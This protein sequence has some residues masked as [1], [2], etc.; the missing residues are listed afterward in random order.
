MWPVVIC[1][2]KP[3]GSRAVVLSCCRWSSKSPKPVKLSGLRHEGSSVIRGAPLGPKGVADGMP[4][5]AASA[6]SVAVGVQLVAIDETGVFVELVVT[7]E[8]VGVLEVV[9]PALVSLARAVVDVAV[10]VDTLRKLKTIKLL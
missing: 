7:V 6:P 8:E 2:G 5:A 1:Q 3:P 10:V 4:A 9:L